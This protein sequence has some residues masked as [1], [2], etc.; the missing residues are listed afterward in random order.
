ML[1]TGLVTG[2][3]SSQSIPVVTNTYSHNNSHS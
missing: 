2:Y 3:K 1:R